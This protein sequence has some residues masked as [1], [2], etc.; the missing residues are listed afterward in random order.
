MKLRIER[1]LLGFA[2]MFV[3]TGVYTPS[4]ASAAETHIAVSIGH[5]HHH[6]YRGH[7]VVYYRHGRRYRVYRHY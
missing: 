3:L 1:W 4:P 6:H 5:T 2:L 7:Y